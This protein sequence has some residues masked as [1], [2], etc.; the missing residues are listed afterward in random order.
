M[1]INFVWECG[2]GG[3]KP[4]WPAQGLMFKS[5][6]DINFI[7]WKEGKKIGIGD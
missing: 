5:Q 6:Y 7:V 4:A 2:L 3:R 1:S